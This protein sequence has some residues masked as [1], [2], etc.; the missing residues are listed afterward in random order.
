MDISRRSFFKILVA[1]PIAA[2]LPK[3]IFAPEVEAAAIPAVKD[4][5]GIER[6]VSQRP[7][8]EGNPWC[9][10]YATKHCEIMYE[11]VMLEDEMNAGVLAR[12]DKN[13]RF[14]ISRLVAKQ[15]R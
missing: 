13:A 8:L 15:V 7:D 5:G 10:S 3:I 2:A 9:V 14:A 11:T 1:V 12:C 6:I 4:L